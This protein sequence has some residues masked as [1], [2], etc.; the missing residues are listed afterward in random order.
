MDARSRSPFAYIGA[1]ALSALAA[2]CASTGGAT[3]RPFPAATPPRA[4]ASA[5]AA[6]PEEAP[7]PVEAANTDALLATALEL[8][9]VPYQNGGSTV[10]GFDC[11]GFTQYVFAQHGLALPREVREQFKIGKPIDLDQVVPGDLVF[12]KTVAPGASHV[13]IALSGD[14]FVHAPSSTGVVRVERYSSA[15]WARRFVGAR[16]ITEQ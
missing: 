11:S 2:G 15:Y 16:R 9:G 1:L 4:P 3:P 8:L 5:P 6:A 12:F 10:D 14:T 7:L 13:G